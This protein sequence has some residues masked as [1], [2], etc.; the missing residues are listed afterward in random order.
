MR[1]HCSTES[2]AAMQTPS[3]LFGE[4]EWQT[5]RLRC[6]LGSNGD[7]SLTFRR[8][9]MANMPASVHTLR[10]SAPVVLGHRRASNS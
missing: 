8:A 9:R 10:R 3:L 6:T 7:E 4:Q 5:C 1:L 2:I